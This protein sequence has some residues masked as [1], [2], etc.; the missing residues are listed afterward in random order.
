MKVWVSSDK[1]AQPSRVWLLPVLS[2][3]N[4][5][6]QILCTI[7]VL[8]EPVALSPVPDCP[9]TLTMLCLLSQLWTKWILALPMSCSQAWSK[10]SWLWA[11]HCGNKV[12]LTSSLVFQDCSYMYA[13][14]HTHTSCCFLTFSNKRRAVVTFF[15]SSLGC[16]CR[17][18]IIMLWFS[19]FK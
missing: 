19:V 2:R 4:S 1:E 7:R 18:K 13:H 17:A 15:F 3:W 12:L 9:E 11:T 8:P 10:S 16:I 14:A 6:F 5:N